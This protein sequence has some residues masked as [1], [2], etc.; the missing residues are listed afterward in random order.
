VIPLRLKTHYTIGLGFCKNDQIIEQVKKHGYK[1]VANT[2][3]NSLS[4][5]VE[6]NAEISEAGIQPILGI[7][8]TTVENGGTLLLLAKN[9]D[10]WKDLIKIASVSN[11]PELYKDT[12][13]ISFGHLP[14]NGNLIC[15]TGYADSYAA[16]AIFN[17]DTIACSTVEDI[18]SKLSMSCVQDSVEITNKLK[19]IFGEENLF[20][21]VSLDG[22]PISKVVT[23][24]YRMVAKETNTKVV[25]LPEIYYA[26]LEDAVDHHISLCSKLKITIDDIHKCTT[27]ESKFFKADNRCYYIK[28]VEEWLAFGYTQEEIDNT[29]LIGGMCSS[30]KLSSGHLLP[31][32]VWTDGMSQID[33][34]KHLCREGWKRKHKGDWDK[35]V[36]GDRVKYEL[37]VI[38]RNNLAGYFLIV[39]DFI[40]WAKSERILV[41]IARGSSGGSLVA[42]LLNI[43]EID[44]IKRKLSFERFFNEGRK[45]NLP[46]IDT[47]FPVRH[48]ERVIQYIKARYGLDRVA[49][50][51]TFGRLQGRGAVTEVMRIHN[52]ASMF[53]IKEV[54]ECI[55]QKEEI[56]DQLED[57]GETSII[58][59]TLKNEPE[60]LEQYCKYENG[61]F[62]GQYAKSFEQAA[63]IEGTIKTKGQHAAGI[64]I[65]PVD[66]KDICPIYYDKEGN[67]VTALDM[68]NAKILGL[69]KMDILGTAIL[70]KLMGVNNLLRYGRINV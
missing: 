61:Q 3:L 40:N 68:D 12:P 33:Y 9:L 41:G 45:G 22:N 25:A 21:G 2:D 70:D 59:W 27:E 13:R 36:Y 10:G 66:L 65:S 52:V 7:E 19:D 17:E 44:P 62:T 16:K 53:T 6:F 29:E 56:S 30:Y 8:I 35:K 1:M 46:D 18:Q 60:K 49:N 58:M 15:I 67:M 51:A 54:T 57:S 64:I 47:D 38:E 26:A 48:R 55:P 39:Q 28:S 37:E 23:E 50:M 11:T 31:N 43:I 69:V 32:Y 34:I 42:Y 20:I 14:T 24:I 5:S 4:G 63:R